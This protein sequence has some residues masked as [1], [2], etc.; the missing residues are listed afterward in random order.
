MTWFNSK[1]SGKIPK[2]DLKL[3][4]ETTT[5]A[6]SAFFVFF[7]WFCFPVR[8]IWCPSKE[9]LFNNKNPSN[10]CREVITLQKQWD[11]SVGNKLFPNFRSI[12]FDYLLI[13]WVT[14]YAHNSGRFR[15]VYTRRQKTS[16]VLYPTAQDEPSQGFSQGH[17]HHTSS[18][19]P[20]ALSRI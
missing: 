10:Y 18:R 12:P 17:F 1:E 7:Y 11:E 5:N 13:S 6:N 16:R 8:E 20:S 9:K 4:Q 15:L 14:N 3:L 2:D 19:K